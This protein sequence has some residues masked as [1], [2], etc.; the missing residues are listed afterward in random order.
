L[1]RRTVASY[2]QVADKAV[3]RIPAAELVERQVEG[4]RFV[5]WRYSSLAAFVEG[6]EGGL[7]WIGVLLAV[8]FNEYAHVYGVLAVAVF[9]LL[10]LTAA[11]FDFRG[12]RARLCDE[13]LIYIEREVGRFY[14]SDSGGAILRLKN[15]LTE[16]QGRQTE[17]LSAG[18]SHLATVL[19]E[20]AEGLGK[21]ITETTKGINNQIAE[22]IKEKLVDMNTTFTSTLAAWEKALTEA[23]AIQTGM[24]TSAEALS[25]AGARLQSSAELL[26]AHL[27][28]HSNALS[29]Q[30]IQLVRA[31]ESVKEIAALLEARQETMTRQSEYIQRN[32]EALETALASYE[33]SLQG[34]TQSLG[35]GLGAFIS[36]HAQSSAQA[37]NDA[38]RGNLERIMRLS[39]HRGDGP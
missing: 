14:A 9:L 28:G 10:R 4:L 22:A 3:T 36:L 27:Q 1:L 17:A 39:S 6:F 19:T 8:V 26:S 15:E 21:T 16:A 31:V 13:L 37:V 7:L 32:Q 29:D 23:T 38:L 34:L 18:L 20:N 35:D 24:N 12:E 11:V 30:L 2:I 5:G 25:K 33:A